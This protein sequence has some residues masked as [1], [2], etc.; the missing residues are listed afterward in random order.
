MA[1]TDGG[2]QRWT[3]ADGGGLIGAPRNRAGGLDFVRER[4]QDVARATTRLTRA[5]RSARKR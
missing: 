5:V 1:T 2:G 3:A 4:H